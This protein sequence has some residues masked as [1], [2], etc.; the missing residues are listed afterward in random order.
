MMILFTDYDDTPLID[1]SELKQAA[2]TMISPET[3]EDDTERDRYLQK[4]QGI[5][6]TTENLSLATTLTLDET[7]EMQKL[8]TE[9]SFFKNR[10]LCMS[11]LNC[12][13][14]FQLRNKKLDHLRR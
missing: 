8:K 10:F 5:V 13:S 12:G 9:N 2:T 7:A 6:V 14:L 1:E 11:A 3:I 4:Y